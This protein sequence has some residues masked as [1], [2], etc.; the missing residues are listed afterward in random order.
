MLNERPQV[1]DEGFLLDQSRWT[2][3]LAE[4]LARSAGIDR[5]TD[6]HWKV[7]ALCREETARGGAL[8]GAGEI[9]KLAGLDEEQL[10]EL[11][12]GDPA[13]LAAKIAG[14]PRPKTTK[15]RNNH[16]EERS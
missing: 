12:P 8:T 1:D 4:L 16:S 9:S 14:L 3:E 15:D 10:R 7:L 6:K 11:F 2:P 13:R 5:L